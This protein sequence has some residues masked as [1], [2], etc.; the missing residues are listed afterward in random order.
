MPMQE[1][2]LDFKPNLREGHEFNISKL[3]QWSVG[4]AVALLA[5]GGAIMVLLDWR[6]VQGAVVQ[7]DWQTI[8]RSRPELEP[9]L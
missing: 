7:A 9:G 4:D 3:R 1:S 5:L 6:D 2:L 8:H